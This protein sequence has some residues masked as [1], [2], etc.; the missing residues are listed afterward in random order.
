MENKDIDNIR[1][2]YESGL[3]HLSKIIKWLIAVIIL[4]ILALVGTNLA[5][6][7]YESQ[8]ET[9]SVEE[10]NEVSALQFG[11]ENVVSG[12]DINYGHTDSQNQD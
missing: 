2:G 10:E 9:V 4:L 3:V 8:F 5:W 6:T 12:G 7:I 11:D 1:Y